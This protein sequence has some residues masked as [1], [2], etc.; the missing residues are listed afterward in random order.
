M[1]GTR[2]ARVDDD[3]SLGKAGV[4]CAGWEHGMVLGWAKWDAVHV[5][6]E[7]SHRNE[8]LRGHQQAAPAR[9]RKLS[10]MDPGIER[11]MHLQGSLSWHA[12]SLLENIQSWSALV[13]VCLVRGQDA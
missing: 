8:L 2:V 3:G 4:E 1:A 7:L 6:E 11:R 5:S 9:Q 13:H 10:E 12:E